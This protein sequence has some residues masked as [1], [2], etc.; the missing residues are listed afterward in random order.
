MVGV[1]FALYLYCCMNLNELLNLS[2]F[3]SSYFLLKIIPLL[4]H[5]EN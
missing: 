1:K 2:V 3:L 4:I 5:W